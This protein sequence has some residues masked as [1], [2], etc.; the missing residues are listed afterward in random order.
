MFARINDYLRSE[1]MHPVVWLWFPCGAAL[2]ATPLIV[3]GALLVLVVTLLPN[4]ILG[5]LA[6]LGSLWP[7]RSSS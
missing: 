6:R 1:G 2:V 5:W 3:A 4:G 7:G